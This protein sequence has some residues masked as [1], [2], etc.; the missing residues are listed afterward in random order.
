MA[1]FDLVVLGGGSAGESIA[2]NVASAPG[3]VR[4]AV[5]E[6]QRVGGEC[7]FVSCMPSKALLRSASARHMIG[8]SVEL[9]ATASRVRLDDAASAFAAAV[10]RRDR[11]AEHRDDAAKA[12]SL[13]SAGATLLRGRG[14]IT[15]PGAVMVNGARHTWKDLVIATGSVPRRPDIPGLADAPTWTSDQALSS[16]ELPP[17]LVILGGGAVGC[18]L[19][20][21]YAR[22]GVRVTLI[23]MEVHLL[24]GEDP[25]VGDVLAEALRADG[26]ELRLTAQA[27]LVSASVDGATVTL[28][29]GSTVIGT[30]ILIAAGRA[31]RTDDLGLERLNITAGGGGV[32]T[33]P[34]GRVTGQTNVW[35]AGDVTGVAPFTHTANYQ[36]RIITS[37]LLGGHVTADYRAIPRAVYTDPTVASVGLTTDQA[38]TKGIDVAVAS[39]DLASTA[40]ATVDEARSGLLIL[41]ADRARRLLVGASAVGAHADE[42]IAEATLAIRAEVPLNLFADVVHAFPTFGEA[43]EPP[44][45]ALVDRCTIP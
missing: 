38:R 33:D 29:D 20:Q 6:E 42:W 24:P 10:R 40:R 17:S 9:G 14:T 30:R 8:R 26:I 3:K 35:A 44:L 21:V 45:R 4:V 32:S 7:P 1:D 22:F 23:D 13:A 5:V 19:A 41:I 43:Y 16:S 39:L 34:D 2:K 37:N 25:T 11:V 12:E 36:A 28:D 31:P 27:T 15:G 18:E